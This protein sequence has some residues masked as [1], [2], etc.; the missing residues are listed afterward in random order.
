MFD[1]IPSTT[2]WPIFVLVW[3]IVSLLVGIAIGKV[4]RWCDTPANRYEQ[5][6]AVAERKRRLE[7][8]GFKSRMGVQ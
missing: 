2:F 4:I 5:K 6:D 7:R 8:N 1:A 3:F